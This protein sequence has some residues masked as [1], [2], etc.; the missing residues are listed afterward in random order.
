M[1]LARKREAHTSKLT[2][3]HR[4]LS[5]AVIPSPRPHHLF[6]CRQAVVRYKSQA[7]T[8]SAD[9]EYRTQRIL[10][11]TFI[12]AFQSIPLATMHRLQN[13]NACQCNMFAFDKRASIHDPEKTFP[14]H[15]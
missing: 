1:W 3:R 5:T 12:D 7:P 2:S 9:M 15:S 11:S 8:S 10:H 13:S 4:A 6:G 14:Q